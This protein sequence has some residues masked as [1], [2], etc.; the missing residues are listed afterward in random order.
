MFNI[1]IKRRTEGYVY[2]HL[3]NY[4][5]E[6]EAEKISIK[7]I[8]EF[9][10]KLSEAN[11]EKNRNILT[12]QPALASGKIIR[13][14]AVIIRDKSELPAKSGLA[15]NKI[16]VA[17]QTTPHYIPYAKYAKGI[18]TDEGGITCH[19][20]IIAREENKP[21]IIGTKNGTDLIKDG[22]IVEMNMQNG[23]VKIIRK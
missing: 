7:N 13:G 21:C 23:Q 10:S 6:V 18:I 16:I 8:R 20:A 4:R 22:D 19:A 17:I 1:I 11:A 12:G 9:F 15:L 3:R 2:M 14:K 5:P